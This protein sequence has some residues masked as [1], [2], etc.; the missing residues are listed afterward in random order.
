MGN[1]RMIYIVKRRKYQ[2]VLSDNNEY[3]RRQF[4]YNPI[5]LRV[6]LDAIKAKK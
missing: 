6:N 1:A 3:D 4:T 2:I 5:A